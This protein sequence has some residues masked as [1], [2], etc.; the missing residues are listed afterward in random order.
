MFVSFPDK[1]LIGSKLVRDDD[2]SIFL[3]GYLLKDVQHLSVGE[4]QPSPVP[5]SNFS[6]DLLCASANG[7]HD[8]HPIRSVPRL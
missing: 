7:P 2:I 4:P 6:V 5:D 3:L 8:R 1:C